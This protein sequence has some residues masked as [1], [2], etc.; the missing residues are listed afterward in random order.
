[1]RSS[2]VVTVLSNGWLRSGRVGVWLL[3]AVAAA[4]PGISQALEIVLAP[5][6]GSATGRVGET[7]SIGIDLVIG[8]DEFVTIADPTL[9]W[10]L[11][12]G[13]VL[14][15]ATALNSGAVAGQVPLAPLRN[16]RWRVFDPTSIDERGRGDDG[17]PIEDV[18]VIGDTRF[19]AT[20]LWGFEVTTSVVDDDGILQIFRNGA[21]EPGTY[22]IGVV[23]F[24]LK[25]IGTTTISYVTDE[26]FAFGSF[27]TGREFVELP[28]DEIG[29]QPL[30]IS[31]T[32]F[33]SLQI[34][35]IPEPTTGALLGLGLMGLSL[36]RGM[37][38]SPDGRSRDE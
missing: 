24:L 28:N 14:D 6:G 1:M 37:L 27:F 36:A 11:E 34:V 38:P 7:L 18:S 21:F 12:G 22:R 15:A 33:A 4:S 5:I 3:V 8:E 35:V 20:A 13:D 9:Q 2:N 16:D 29:L 19:G 31:A 10:D 23:D 32:D 17:Y 26:R 30:E 25:Q